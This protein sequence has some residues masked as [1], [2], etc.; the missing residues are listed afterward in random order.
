MWHVAWQPRQFLRRGART[1]RRHT[2]HRRLGRRTVRCPGDAT[3]ARTARVRAARCVPCCVNARRGACSAA[4]RGACVTCR[5]TADGHAPLT[6][7]LPLYSRGTRRD[8]STHELVRIIDLILG[9]AVQ[10]QNQT[11]T[12]PAHSE[13]HTTRQ[14]DELH[15]RVRA[16]VAPVRTGSA[17]RS[18]STSATSW[19]STRTRRPY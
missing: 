12:H 2:P 7:G 3:R 4:R 13:S 11:N 5:C 17:R 8:A 19:S 1:A 10:V 16:R 14:A 6:R 9:C 15:E 18:R